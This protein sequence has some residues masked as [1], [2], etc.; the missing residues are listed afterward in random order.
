[1]SIWYRIITCLF[2]CLHLLLRCLD[3]STKTDDTL[4]ALIFKLFVFQQYGLV[5]L[6]FLNVLWAQFTSS[7]ILTVSECGYIITAM[8]MS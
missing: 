6:D 7:M 5:L 2:S 3:E 1:M 8:T 4:S